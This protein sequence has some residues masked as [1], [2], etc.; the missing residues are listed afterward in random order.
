[1]A[2]NMKSHTQLVKN[3][4][5]QKLVEAILLTLL[6]VLMYVSQVIMA[7]LPNIEIVTLLIILTTRKFGYKAFVSVYIFVVCEIFT[8]GLE[9]WV[10][11]YLYVWAILCVLILIIKKIDEAIVYALIAAIYGLFFG[12]LCSVP[13][14]I[15]GGIAGGIAYIIQGFVFDLLHCGGNFVLVLLMYKPLTR[16]MNKIIK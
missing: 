1:M 16:V 5:H 11:N 3:N 4:R 14:F 8:Y 10:I 7:A 15:M 6:G 9:I 12:T 2:I 13:Y